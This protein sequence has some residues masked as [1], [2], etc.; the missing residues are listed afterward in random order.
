ML[1]LCIIIMIIIIIIIILISHLLHPKNTHPFPSSHLCKL[2]PLHFHPQGRFL[3]LHHLHTDP[4]CKV[5]HA[6]ADLYPTPARSTETARWSLALFALRHFCCAKR[7]TLRLG[8]WR[9]LCSVNQVGIIK[10]QKDG[11]MK[12]VFVFTIVSRSLPKTTI[13]SKY[14]GF[15]GVS[16]LRGPSQ[17]AFGGPNAPIHPQAIW[18]TQAKSGAS[19]RGWWWTPL[20]AACSTWVYAWY[21]Y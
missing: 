13:L 18:K 8:T 5:W 2:H 11:K 21:T 17:E 16:N 3:P 20:F 4:C 7:K 19:G 12:G 14:L 15:G 1:I 10:Q 6:T 9:E